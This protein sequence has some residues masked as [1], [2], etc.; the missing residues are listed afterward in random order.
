MRRCVFDRNSGVF[1]AERVEDVTPGDPLAYVAT[2]PDGIADWRLSLN[3]ETHEVIV[4]YPGMTDEEADA[5][6]TADA[7]AEALAASQP[8]P[9][10]E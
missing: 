10:A 2:A 6:N 1:W 5:Q 8:E 3:T 7:D 4:R 9:P